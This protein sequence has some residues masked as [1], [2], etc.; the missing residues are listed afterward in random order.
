MVAFKRPDRLADTQDLRFVEFENNS[1]NLLGSWD[2]ATNPSKILDVCMGTCALGDGAFVLYQSFEGQMHLQFKFFR[3][4]TM[5]VEPHCP[6]EA[7]CIGS[8]ID[9]KSK[10]SILL[11]GG[12]RV[13]AFKPKEYLS[14]KG[15]GEVIDAGDNLTSLR[16]LQVSQVGEILRLWYTTTDDAVHY[17]TARTT[18]L[19]QGV[20]GSLLPKGQGGRISS[21]IQLRSTSQAGKGVLVSSLV[22][23]DQ[24]GNLTLLQQDSASRVWQRFPLWHADAGNIIELKGY[25]LRMQAVSSTDNQNALSDDETLLIPGCWLRVSCSGVVRCKVNGR[26][27][28]LSPTAQWLQTNAR[29]I[30]NII[31]QSDDMACHQFVADA[32]R[33]AKQDSREVLLGNS[34]ILDPSKK[35]A[36]KL[37]HV[38]DPSDLR[39]L[40]KPDGSPL[41]DPSASHDDVKAATDS[42]R[43]LVDQ[44]HSF[45]EKSDKSFAAHR[46]TVLSNLEAGSPLQTIELYSFGDFIGDIVDGLKDGWHWIEQGLEDAWKWGCEFVGEYSQPPRVFGSG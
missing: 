28:T 3:G 4:S 24:H 40:R 36:K 43:T 13:V 34:D 15:T 1:A 11:I 39:A 7:T 42:I 38:K 45:H 21:L 46:M 32:F 6:P 5:V 10:Q 8:Y 33:A 2:L 44:V 19:S 25:M 16:D 35:V 29:G 23:V 26:E 37:D 30:L 22:S 31:M 27:V 20:Q 9:P 17:Y 12:P 18:S 41:I 14:P